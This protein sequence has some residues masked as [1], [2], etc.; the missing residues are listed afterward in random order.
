MGVERKSRFVS[1][2][3][4]ITSAYVEAG[5]ALVALHTPASVPLHKVSILPRGSKLSVTSQVPGIDQDSISKSVFL[6]SVH[7]VLF[8]CGCE[9]RQGFFLYLGFGD[10]F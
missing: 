5:H 4:L 7:L 1:A 8:A 2:E 6:L 9:R 3:S 10:V